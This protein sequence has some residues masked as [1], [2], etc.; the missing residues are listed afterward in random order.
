MLLY[1]SVVM[2]V[3]HMCKWFDSMTAKFEKYLTSCQH[4]LFFHQQ[5]KERSQRL[6]GLPLEESRLRWASD[7]CQKTTPLNDHIDI[8][9]LLVVNA[10]QPGR[11]PEPLPRA[12]RACR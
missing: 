1:S 7:T 11:L 12:G 6:Q 9:S 4:C 10:G 2:D 5:W 3:L 8:M